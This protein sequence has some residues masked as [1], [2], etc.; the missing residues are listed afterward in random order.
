MNEYTASGLRSF[1]G[2]VCGVLGDWLEGW[3]CSTGP[4]RMGVFFDEPDYPVIDKA[5]QFWKT[6]DPACAA[7][8][9]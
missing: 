3:S 2:V 4:E 1:C 7:C 9:N 6:G 5:P 8:K